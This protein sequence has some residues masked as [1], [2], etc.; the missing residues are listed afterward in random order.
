MPE[1]PRVELVLWWREWGTGK[2]DGLEMLEKLYMVLRALG[3][4]HRGVLPQRSRGRTLRRL[5]QTAQYVSALSSM[6][7]LR[8]AVTHSAGSAS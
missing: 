8:I 5:Y 4:R 3:M 2:D 6:Q 1:S 7:L